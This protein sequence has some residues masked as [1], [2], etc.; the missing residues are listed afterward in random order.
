VSQASPAVKSAKIRIY[1]GYSGSG[2]LPVGI[3][4]VSNTAWAENT[5]TWNNKPATSFNPITT[6]FINSTNQ[7]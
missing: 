3:Y 6:V 2:L 7:F 1:G 4:S 5:I